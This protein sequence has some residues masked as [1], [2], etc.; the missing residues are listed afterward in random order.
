MASSLAY[1]LSLEGSNFASYSPG[2][3]KLAS[4][5]SARVRTLH[6]MGALL[7][8]TARLDVLP[9]V[10][11]G[12]DPQLQR[13]A[14]FDVV[15]SFYPAPPFTRK[16]LA[17]SPSSATFSFP[18]ALRSCILTV[19]DS[20]N[21]SFATASLLK[22]TGPSSGS[23]FGFASV[24]RALRRRRVARRNQARLC[25]SR[26]GLKHANDTHK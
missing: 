16:S 17:G 24:R 2:S 3:G 18:L 25:Q 9:G 22:K 13:V 10:F 23:G 12:A 21:A 26:T 14:V 11:R 8:M 20:T 4:S 7:N 15:V 19:F 6:K 5:W 1:R